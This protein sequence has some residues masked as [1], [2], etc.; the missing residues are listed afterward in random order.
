[1]NSY[2]DRRCI[3]AGRVV[4]SISILNGAMAPPPVEIEP[5]SL[6]ETRLR[7][8]VTMFMIDPG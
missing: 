5:T 1:M 8:L 2:C 4:T 7:G 6:P 3:V